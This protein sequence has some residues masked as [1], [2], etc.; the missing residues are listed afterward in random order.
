MAIDAVAAKMMG[1]DPM[2]IP[3]IRMATEMGLGCGEPR[4]IE[5]IG[6]NVGE[7]N[8][9]FRCKRSLVIMGDQM[10][11]KGWLRPLDRVLLHSPLMFWAPL[12]SNIYHDW[13][14]YPTKGKKAI[15]EFMDTEWGELFAR[16]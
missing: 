9:G 1:F 2:T 14:W 10:I 16:Y 15:R 11:R 4:E 7:V 6:D 3:Y 13:Y 12:A 5:V 8:F